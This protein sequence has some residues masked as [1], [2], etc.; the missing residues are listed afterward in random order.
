MGQFIFGLLLGAILGV[1]VCLIADVQ[2]AKYISK[3]T[4]KMCKCFEYVPRQEK[5]SDKLR[6]VEKACISII[7]NAKE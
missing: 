4:N 3:Q 6:L 7:N 1:I 5:M 2:E